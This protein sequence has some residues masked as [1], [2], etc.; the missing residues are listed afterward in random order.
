MDRTNIL[1]IILGYLTL[2]NVESS[3]WF[4][5]KT[6]RHRKAIADAR[7]E[8]AVRADEIRFEWGRV[9][10]SALRFASVGRIVIASLVPGVSN[11]IW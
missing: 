1:P 2:A 11:L 9:V 3:N 7:F 10:K 4:M 6:N 5:T 8:K